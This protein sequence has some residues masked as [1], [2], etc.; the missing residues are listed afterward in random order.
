[1]FLGKEVGHI[2]ITAV[3]VIKNVLMPLA[4]GAGNLSFPFII[5]PVILAPVKPAAITPVGY[6]ERSHMVR[7]SGL[8][9]TPLA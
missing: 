7:I 6:N 8:V 5:S 3:S 9:G 4:S 2:V 1:M